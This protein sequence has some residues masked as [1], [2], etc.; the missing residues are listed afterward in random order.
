MSEIKP[1]TRFKQ[2]ETW[3]WM[4]TDDRVRVYRDHC[5]CSI[6]EAREYV[7]RDQ[8]ELEIA[9]AEDVTDLRRIL[10]ALLPYINLSAEPRAALAQ[11]TQP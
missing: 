11:E 3:R 2:P 1:A 4:Y 6:R 9:N 10:Q 8:L 5:K 7:L